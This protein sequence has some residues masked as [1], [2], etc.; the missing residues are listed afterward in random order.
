M[1][2]FMPSLYVRRHDMTIVAGAPVGGSGGKPYIG[3]LVLNA[4][5][6]RV[7]AKQFLHSRE[8]EF[9]S[10]GREG[11]VID[12]KGAKIGLAICAD[13]T[14]PVHARWAAQSGAAIYAAGVLITVDG[15]APDAKLLRQ[16]AA[17]HKMTVLMANHC[18]PTGGYMP[19]GKSAIWDSSG[20]LLATA[21]KTGESLVVA[22]EERGCWT[23]TTIRV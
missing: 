3:A 17:E 8:D 21:D 6:S 4:D 16:Y 22:V 1:F 2:R 14:H 5:I 18:S 23:G 13:T 19:A 20:T 7:Y 12:V 15:Y 10:P 11:C 9:F